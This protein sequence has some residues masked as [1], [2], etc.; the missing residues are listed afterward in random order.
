M[1]VVKLIYTSMAFSKLLPVFLSSFLLLLLHLQFST[2]QNVVKSAY[3]FSGSEY[4]VADIDSTLFTHLFCAFADLNSQ[5]NQ[6][7]V[8]SANQARFST[9]TTT[10]QQKNPSV[11]T[12]LSIGGG[13]ANKAAFAFMA[14]QASSRKSFIDSSIRLARTNGFHGLDIDWEYPE[15]SAQM[16]N[17]GVLLKEWRTAVST[18]SRSS[19]KLPLL[20][21]AAVSYSSNYF[22][23]INPVQ[24]I[25]NSLD[26]INVM[27]YDFTYRADSVRLTGPPAALYSPGT[28]ISGDAGIRAWI[29]S[30][31]PSNKIVIG[32]P[33]YGHSLRLAD[34]N[35]HG[36]FAPTNGEVNGG[37]MGYKQ[38]RQFISQN[39][40][41]QVY[42]STVVS[43]YCYSGTTWIGY[44]DTQS[45]STK[46]RYA[47]GKSLLGYF[48]WHLANDDNWILTREASR[49]WGA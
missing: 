25:S 46:V 20:L 43:D 31:M 48:A 16:A 14:S 36:F 18:E 17:F 41:T 15:N 3:W 8:S 39:R 47:K 21:S 24:A 37:A 27:A 34:A 10:V 33:Y 1:K 19:G 28:Q 23:V 4:P 12:L 5:N 49:A 7:T 45:V 6:V 32:F 40:A 22:G 30:G 29:Q 42:N 38:I 35:N 44:D 13:N 9:F 11:K 2:A 26:W